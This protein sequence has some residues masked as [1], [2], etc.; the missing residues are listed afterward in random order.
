[1][2]ERSEGIG[3]GHLIMCASP[4]ELLNCFEGV[5]KNPIIDRKCPFGDGNSVD[6]ILEIL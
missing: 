2:T 4:H 1:M 3:S 5:A 6:K